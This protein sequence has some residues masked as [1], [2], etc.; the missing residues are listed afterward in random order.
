MTTMDV[1]GAQYGSGSRNK[2]AIS[3]EATAPAAVRAACVI[4][5]GFSL[6]TTN[7]RITFDSIDSPLILCARRIAGPIR[8]QPS[9]GER[10]HCCPLRSPLYRRGAGLFAPDLVS[11]AGPISS[12]I[13]THSAS[14]TEVA[15]FP[16]SASLLS[17]IE[18]TKRSPRTV[19]A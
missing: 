9:L 8:P 13:A 5:V 11:F 12:T 7:F 18:K 16:F 1:I 19:V 15:S 3:N 4:D 17:I 6:A 2:R 10:T 14:I